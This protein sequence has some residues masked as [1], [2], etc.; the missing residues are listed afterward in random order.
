MLLFWF[1]SPSCALR[2]ISEQDNISN[3]FVKL[4]AEHMLEG[5][6]QTQTERCVV[7]CVLYIRVIH[8]APSAGSLC[9]LP[10]A[11]LC[12]HSPRG[13]GAGP[14]RAGRW[15]RADR[16][17]RARC[18][19]GPCPMGLAGHRGWLGCWQPGRAPCV[20]AGAVVPWHSLSRAG[21]E[22]LPWALPAAQQTVC[23]GSVTCPG[24]GK[25]QEGCPRLVLG[26]SL[27]HFPLLKRLWEARPVCTTGSI[28]CAKGID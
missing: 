19:A 5:F 18:L 3:Q 12:V 26:A 13:A 15:G 23:F 4:L 16:S 20:L 21:F 10:A 11:D 28:A 6:K 25:E 24:Q 1:F 14:G 7:Y 17:G 27:S 8:M 22:F 2:Q 9:F